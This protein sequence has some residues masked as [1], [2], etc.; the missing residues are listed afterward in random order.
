MRKTTAIAA[1]LLAACSGQGGNEQKADNGASASG[2]SG[3]AG[4]GDNVAVGSESTPSAAA[5]RLQAGEWESTVEVL[6]MTMSNLPNMPAGMAPPVPPAVT[7]RTCLTAA[8]VNRPN[9]GFFTGSAQA[10]GCTYENFSMAGGRIQGIVQCNIAG[11]TSRSTISGQ[12]T[13]TS[14]EITSQVQATAAGISTDQ[15]TRVRARRVGECPG[16]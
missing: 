2:E 1:L 4:A 8:Q 7:T 15:E 10:A 12:F 9:A 5:V 14:Y 16:G 13:P 3:G 11:T 6:R